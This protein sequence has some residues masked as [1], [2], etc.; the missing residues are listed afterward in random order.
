MV[1]GSPLAFGEGRVTKRV[2]HVLRYK[3]TSRFVCV[4]SVILALVLGFGFSLDRAFGTAEVFSPPEITVIIWYEQHE[5]VSH[6]RKVEGCPCS[7]KLRCLF[8]IFPS[9]P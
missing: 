1:A 8:T 6:Q 9:L 5:V 7:F 2:K 4:T 3:K